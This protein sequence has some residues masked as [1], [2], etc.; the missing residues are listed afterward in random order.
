M[1]EKNIRDIIFK[2]IDTIAHIEISE[3][4]LTDPIDSF[5]IDSL[6]M[7]EIIFKIETVLNIEID[8][9]EIY[10]IKTFNNLLEMVYKIKK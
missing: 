5:K 2:I 7:Y 4:N 3:H 9:E 8:D 1:K 6:M 10:K